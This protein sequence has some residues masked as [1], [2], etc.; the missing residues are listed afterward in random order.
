MHHAHARPHPPSGLPLL[1]CHH[2]AVAGVIK[3]CL[4]KDDFI[5][6]TYRDHVHALSKGVSARK[7]GAAPAAAPA[8]ERRRLQRQRCH[9]PDVA[10]P[11]MLLHDSLCC[12]FFVPCRSWRS[13][14][15]RR[16]AAA[17]ARAAPCTCLTASLGW[18]VLHAGAGR[19]RDELAWGALQRQSC[20]RGAHAAPRHVQ[21]AQHGA[22]SGGRRRCA[23]ARRAPTPPAAARPSPCFFSSSRQLGGYAFIG[24]GIPVGL[25]AAF[26]VAYSQR[27]LGNEQDDRVSVNFFGDGTCNVGACSGCWAGLRDCDSFAMKDPRIFRAAE[28]VWEVALGASPSTSSA[29]TPAAGRDGS[30]GGALRDPI[31]RTRSVPRSRSEAALTLPPR[32]PGNTHSNAASRVRP[33][34]ADRKL[35]LPPP[36]PGLAGQFYEALNMATLYKLPCIFVV[37]NNK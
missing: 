21:H 19:A 9:A 28:T 22:G 34:E 32:R 36:S 7:V 13:C 35:R 11:C 27:V 5:C 24:E 4:R 37:E 33:R 10:A 12:V 31:C 17:A 14:L 3:A 15:A 1:C 2:A 6:S 25:G 23:P 16:L 18:W 8:A 29:A 26:Q 20:T 30:I